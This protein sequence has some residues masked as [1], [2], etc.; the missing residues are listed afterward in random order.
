[1]PAEIVL[2]GL[3][4]VDLLIDIL[5][6]HGVDI[7]RLV[8]ESLG[9]LGL[10]SAITSIPSLDKFYHPQLRVTEHEP[11]ATSRGPVIGRR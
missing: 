8:L 7:L 9:F 1:M 5:R 10:I 11:P 6:R 3:D 4:L 2:F